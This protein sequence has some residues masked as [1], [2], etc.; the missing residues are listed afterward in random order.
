[1]KKE[2]EKVIRNG[3]VGILYSPGYGAGWSTWNPDFKQLL[4]HPK[5]IEAVENNKQKDIDEEWLKE[6]KIISKKDFVYC[7]GAS[8]LKIIWLP[9][10]TAFMIDEYDGAESV[11]IVDS[12][13]IIA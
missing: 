11:Q 7:G 4:F 6:N 8:S 10:G 3:D 1:M 2:L 12:L 9:E 13:T 5:L